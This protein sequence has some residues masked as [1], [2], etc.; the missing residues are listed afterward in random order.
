VTTSSGG[1]LQLAGPLSD[2]A[3]ANGGLLVTVH[4]AAG[5]HAG[6]ATFVTPSGSVTATVRVTARIQGPLV[7]LSVTAPVT[8][9]TGV[10]A[11]ARGTLTGSG[12][13]T[14]VFGV[15]YLI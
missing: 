6:T 12:T 5:R 15:G 9:A 14:A 4:P 10:S 8:A 7:H 2:P 11:G 1:V 13:V 3:V